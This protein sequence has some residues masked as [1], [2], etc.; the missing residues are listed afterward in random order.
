MAE[1]THGSRESPKQIQMEWTLPPAMA[2]PV[3]CPSCHSS[4]T[5]RALHTALL[6]PKPKLPVPP[7]RLQPAGKK[8]VPQTEAETREE[9]DTGTVLLL[10]IGE[11]ALRAGYRC[12]N[13]NIELRKKG[14][15]K[16]RNLLRSKVANKKM[17]KDFLTQEAGFFFFANTMQNRQLVC[18]KRTPI[19]NRKD[20]PSIPLRGL[21][22]QGKRKETK[23]PFGISRY[24]ALLW[25]HF[26][27]A[28]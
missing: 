8:Q 22:A 1:T 4:P 10:Y 18:L 19:N 14:T 23:M 24:L 7:S 16:G 17:V 13:Q 11:R 28:H 15:G 6:P 9:W 3:H 2:L 25:L 27:T 12:N 20:T 26:F 5:H 21:R